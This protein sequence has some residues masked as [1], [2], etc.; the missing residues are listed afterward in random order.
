MVMSL[1]KNPFYKNEHLSAEIHIMHTFSN[2]FYGR[3]MRVVVLG[4]I[5]PELD[6]TSRDDLIN[7]IEIDKH[8]AVRC[9]QRPAYGV[10][11]DRE[12]FDALFT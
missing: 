12:T 7:D 6:Y 9:M 2:D 1:G 3:E 5:R 10:F 8:V 11:H 4:Y